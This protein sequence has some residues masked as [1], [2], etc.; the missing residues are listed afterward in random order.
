MKKVQV[1][2]VKNAT[3]VYQIVVFV[4]DVVIPAVSETTISTNIVRTVES[5]VMSVLS[6][7]EK[8]ALK[9]IA[10][11]VKRNCVSSLEML[12]RPSI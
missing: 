11:S 1:P 9:Y 12:S 10:I 4:H 8:L 5:I 7:W 6:L 2:N 3:P